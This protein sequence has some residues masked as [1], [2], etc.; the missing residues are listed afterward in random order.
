LGHG[1]QPLFSSDRIAEPGSKGIAGWVKRVDL[2]KLA[3]INDKPI[4]RVVA[5][6][7]SR[8]SRHNAREDTRLYTKRH[9]L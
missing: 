9:S 1:R 7:L 8:R 2:K 3:T 5:A 4:T 6:V